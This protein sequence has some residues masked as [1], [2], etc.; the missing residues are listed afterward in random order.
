MGELLPQALMDCSLK[1]FGSAMLTLTNVIQVHSDLGGIGER[2]E[3]KLE[4]KFQ[5]RPHGNL[6]DA[7]V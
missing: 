3:I 5:S 1:A 7:E 4:K 6:P 2:D